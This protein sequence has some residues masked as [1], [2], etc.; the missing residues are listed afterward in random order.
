LEAAAQ[1]LWCGF[2]NAQLHALFAC[3]PLLR[4]GEANEGEFRAHCRNVLADSPS[5]LRVDLARASV[6]T[7]AFALQ[8][9]LDPDAP[10]IKRAQR[11]EYAN[12]IGWFAHRCDEADPVKAVE[13]A[14][15]QGRI[16]GIAA[17]YRQY[18]DEKDPRRQERVARSKAT[19]SARSIGAHE[20][21]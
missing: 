10:S 18:K 12:A 7:L 11:A 9:H 4:F 5:A 16:T 6:E 8:V 3:A 21:V 14:R 17:Q 13:L 15:S 20:S 2:R 1:Q 19:R